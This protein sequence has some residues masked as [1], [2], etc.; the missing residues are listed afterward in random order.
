MLEDWLQCVKEGRR[1]DILCVY[2]LSL[3]TGM[4]TVVHL[5]HNKL[6][7]MLKEIPK[8][9]QELIKWCDKHLAYFVFGIFL[10]LN[11]RPPPLNILGT[12]SG[13]DP[14]TQ[15]LLLASV[16]K[17]IKLEFTGTTSASMDTASTTSNINLSTFRKASAAAGSEAQLKRLESKMKSDLESS[18]Q[19]HKQPMANILP[20]QLKI[21]KL[22]VQDIRKYTS[23]SKHHSD[24]QTK[25][26]K[27][28]L[29]SPKSSPIRT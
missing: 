14:E 21:W 23:T 27:L 10:R 17:Q 6:W 24:T 29:P 4:H 20:F 2:L 18:S 7:C 11:E 22:A 19:P 13:S 16:S 1:G 15:Q 3:A 8:M 25:S 28:N 5:K 26:V 12:V 9:H